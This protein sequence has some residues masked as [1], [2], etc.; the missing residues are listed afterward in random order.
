MPACFAEQRSD[1]QRDLRLVFRAVRIRNAASQ[2]SMSQGATAPLNTRP[3]QI[4]FPVDEI[5]S[6]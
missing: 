3:I 5:E 1:P 6:R 4:V 2:L